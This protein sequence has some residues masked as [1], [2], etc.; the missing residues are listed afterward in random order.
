MSCRAFHQVLVLLDDDEGAMWSVLERAI[1]IAQVERARLTIAKTTDPG[2]MV[3]WLAPLATVARAGLM[4]EPDTESPRCMLDGA[5]ASV[6]AS[7]PLT[8]ILLGENTA[9]AVRRLAESTSYDLAVMDEKFA[10]RNRS[11]LRLFRRL[12]VSTL[13][14]CSDPTAGA[15][16]PAGRTKMVASA[17]AFT[18]TI[19]QEELLD[20]QS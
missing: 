5:T 14:V 13:L 9:R 2:R 18:N 15:D 12:N 20:H 11:V 3:K 8:R 19:R 1:E 4:V 17:P 6:P 10:A 7:I 16:R